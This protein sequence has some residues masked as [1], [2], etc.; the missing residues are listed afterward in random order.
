MPTIDIGYDR[1]NESDR[2][3]SGKIGI[4]LAD[5]GVS[6]RIVVDLSCRVTRYNE[7]CITQRNHLHDKPVG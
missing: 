1:I 7:R 5:R 6:L 2:Q 4:A 3:G